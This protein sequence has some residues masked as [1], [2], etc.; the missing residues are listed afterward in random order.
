MGSQ[1][2]ACARGL[3]LAAGLLALSACHRKAA[4]PPP[5]VDPGFLAMPVD[6]R[7]P[8]T[9]ALVARG[10]DV[11]AKNCVACH[12]QKGDGKGYGAPFLSPPPR[13]FTAGVFKLRTTPSGSMPR[14]EDLYRTISR[15]VTGTAMPAWKWF[16]PDPADRWAL[17]EY[18]KALS[19]RWQAE[20]A[21]AAIDLPAAPPDVDGPA[22]I[23][24][25][26]AV[27]ESMGCASCHGKEG[28]GDGPS[29]LSLR[30]DWDNPLGARDF[31][32]VAGFKGG[33]SEREIAR[34]FLTGLDGTPMPSF[35][36]AMPRDQ[37]WAL[38]AYVKSLG[39][40]HPMH[41][42]A[43][44]GTAGKTREV[45][46]APD[47]R[48]ALLE[49]G[50]HYEPSVVHVK[51]GQVVEITLTTTDNG[52]GAGHGFSIDGMDDESFLNGATVGA[53]KSVKF[54]AARAGTFRF[55]CVTQCSTGYLHPNM[56]GMLIVDPDSRG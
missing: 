21:Q 9:P 1:P 12:G 49:R 50:W 22:S 2:F 52:L 30:D 38:A 26:K 32:N 40:Q 19:P 7:P 28:M 31:T 23:A 56:T 55:H 24:K 51:Q 41:D 29:S 10:R 47:V 6:P 48:I 18:I 4:E 34:T 13:D 15:G 16:L 33:W 5:P 8:S 36:D 17:V 20:K 44:H 37:I 43:S 35:A 11:F 42:V 39:R 3:L 27:Y 45:L 14:D 46:G 54:R 53:P 25:G